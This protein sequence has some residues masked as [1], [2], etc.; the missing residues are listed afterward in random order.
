MQQL[1]LF[2]FSAR[3]RSSVAPWNCYRLCETK[4]RDFYST[5][6][7]KMSAHC[8]SFHF[9]S[10]S[11]W[12]PQFSIVNAEGDVMLRIKGPCCTCQ[13][14]ADIEFEVIAVTTV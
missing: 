4:V 7:S 10:W 1:L 14:C 2:L 13:F 5:N 8:N 6:L 11:L 9:C 3:T 12:L